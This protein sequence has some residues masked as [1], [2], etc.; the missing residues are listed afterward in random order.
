MEEA[1]AAEVIAAVE[2]I[3]DQPEAP[4]HHRDLTAVHQYGQA[5]GQLGRALAEATAV[6]LQVHHDRVQHGQVAQYGK[7]RTR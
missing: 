3:Q 5:L 1:T 4:P 7:D 2:A 6:A